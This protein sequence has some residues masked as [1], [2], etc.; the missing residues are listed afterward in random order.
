L[1]VRASI[2]MANGHN[3]HSDFSD[4]HVSSE[5]GDW[6]PKTISA[7][8]NLNGGGPMLKLSTVTGDIR[9]LRAQ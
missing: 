6:G 5:G 3:I 8:G 7:E 9:I 4:I 1:T 2:D